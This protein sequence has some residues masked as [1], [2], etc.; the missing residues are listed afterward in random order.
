MS[1]QESLSSPFVDFYDT[2]AQIT[3]NTL[4]IALRVNALQIFPFEERAHS[5]DPCWSDYNCKP[6][7]YTNAHAQKAF[8][9][10]K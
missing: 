2:L 7:M 5:R 3:V 6:H 8:D 10:D 1:S 9:A 4:A